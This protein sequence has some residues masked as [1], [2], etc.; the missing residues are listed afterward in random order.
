MKFTAVS[1]AVTAL[2]ALAAPAAA[3][4]LDVWVPKVTYPTAGTVWTYGEVRLVAL[5]SRG[6]Y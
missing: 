6:R 3:S 4:P 1:A 5:H 2:V